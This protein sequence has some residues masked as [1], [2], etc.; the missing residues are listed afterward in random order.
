MDNVIIP[1]SDNS[2]NSDSESESGSDDINSQLLSNNI[3]VIHDKF[4]VKDIN[5]LNPEDYPLELWNKSL[6]YN[7]T[8]TFLACQ[9]F[10][11]IMLNRN[12]GVILNNISVV[13]KILTNRL[14]SYRG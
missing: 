11:K 3:G 9:Q 8:G 5:L 1:Y 4:Q 7:L 2:D 14:I 10:G 6:K 12:K 13:H